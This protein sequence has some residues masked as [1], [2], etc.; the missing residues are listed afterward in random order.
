MKSL[1]IAAALAIIGFSGSASAN[2]LRPYSDQ[3]VVMTNDSVENVEY[4]PR[5]RHH[6]RHHEDGFF[7]EFGFGDRHFRRHYERDYH[8]PR[9]VFRHPPVVRLTRAHVEWCYDHYR[10]YDHRTNTYVRSSGREVFCR[11]PYLR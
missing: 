5:L 4:R 3:Q 10:S 1:I 9:V 6:R 2:E 7:L 8:R 11:S